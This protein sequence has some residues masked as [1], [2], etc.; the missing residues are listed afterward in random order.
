MVDHPSPVPGRKAFAAALLAP[1][2]PVPEGVVGRDGRPAG[3]RF[4]V[5]RNNV[6]VSLTESLK[7]TYPAVTALLGEEYF[8]ALARLYI[9]AHPPQS[10]ILSRYGAELSEFVATF[11]PLAAYPYLADVARFEWAW[12]QSYHAADAPVLAAADLAAVPPE[13]LAGTILTAHPAASV[14]VSAFPV[15]DLV[16]A[17]RFEPEASGSVDLSESQTVLFSRP[18]IDVMFRVIPAGTAALAA[19][20]LDGQALGNAAEQAFEA[21]PAFDFSQGL[22]VL[23]AAGIFGGLDGRAA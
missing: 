23:L 21:D 5:Y 11:A 22:S 6:V 18:D 12:L 15:F 14:L 13:A 2:L 16:I 10:P 3:K 4:A 1:D 9:N 20:L 7:A 8:S 19:A 17:N